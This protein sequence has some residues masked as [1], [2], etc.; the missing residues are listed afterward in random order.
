MLKD[1]GQNIGNR[2]KKNPDENILRKVAFF[3]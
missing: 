1:L 3:F 2:Q